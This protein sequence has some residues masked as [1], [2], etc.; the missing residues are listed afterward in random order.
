MKPALPHGHYRHPFLLVLLALVY[1][2]LRI[3]VFP[4]HGSHLSYIR[5]S[6]AVSPAVN[7]LAAV[8][9]RRKAAD[10]LELP[11]AGPSV[12]FHLQQD[13]VL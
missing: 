13:H 5:Q 3:L 12:A 7:Q 1:N 11:D 8:G 10:P 9:R 6:F 2:G 4:L